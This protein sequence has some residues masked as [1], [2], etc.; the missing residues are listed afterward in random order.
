MIFLPINI[1]P[2]HWY[3]A[4]VNAKKREVQV[5]DSLCWTFHRE[6]LDLTLKGLE[7]HFNI[8]QELDNSICHEWKDLNVTKW[9]IEE[10]L[11]RA[12]QKDSASCGLFVLKFMELWTGDELSRSITQEAVAKFRLK[13]AA[14]LIRW[15]TNVAKRATKSEP[16]K[17]TESFSEDV[18]ILESLRGEAESTEIRPAKRS[19]TSY[20]CIENKYHSLLNVL[21]MVCQMDLMAAL[22]SYVMSVK[23]PETLDKEWVRSSK[24]YPISLSVKNIQ[25]L[26]K[27][28]IETED[29]RQALRES[30]NMGVR[31]LASDNLQMF[32]KANMGVLVHY[33]DLRFSILSDIARHPNYRKTLDAKL[34]AKSF[35]SWPGFDYDVSE[36]LCQ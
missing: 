13:L 15:K 29:G 5:L 11:P 10:V 14:I 17:D 4:V 8:L 7:K 9:P 23:D 26:L 24:P 33:M 34:L 32:K 19:K 28:R 1:N 3:L 2:T 25:E 6:D 22:S 12:I 30:F 36:F 18:E 35:D 27:K 16:T 21:S 31:R 20:L